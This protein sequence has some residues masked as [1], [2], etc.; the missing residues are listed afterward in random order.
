MKPRKVVLVTARSKA[1]LAIVKDIDDNILDRSYRHTRVASIDHYPYKV[2]AVMGEEIAK[3]FK[4]KLFVKVYN[5]NYHL[6]PR[7]SVDIP[8]DE[9]VVHKD[10]F[11]DS[12][13]KHKAY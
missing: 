1:K 4:T 10:V 6:S 13:L 8:L 5:D 12:A 2:T 3:Q 7:Y 9:T 11:R